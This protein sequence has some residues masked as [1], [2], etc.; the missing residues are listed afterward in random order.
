[1]NP[2]DIDIYFEMFWI[3]AVSIATLAFSAVS[4]FMLGYHI[5]HKPKQ[6]QKPV[7]ETAVCPEC[8]GADG[9]HK[10]LCTLKDVAIK[11]TFIIQRN[12]H[13]SICGEQGHY[14][15]KCPNKEKPKDE[16]KTE[17]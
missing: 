5:L 8:G 2:L 16:A 11:T 9:Y 10:A 6:P 1:M 7:A 14:A 3:F 17:N 13:C 4:S 12:P 15:T